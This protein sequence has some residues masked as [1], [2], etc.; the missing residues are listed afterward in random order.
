[1]NEQNVVTEGRR[2]LKRRNAQE[3]EQ[4]IAEYNAGGKSRKEFCEEHGIELS[5]FGGWIK[6]KDAT[7]HAG[8]AEV[9]VPMSEAAPI[10]ITYPAGVRV[11]IRSAGSR[12]DL[13]GL[14]RGL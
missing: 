6:K 11:S 13:V 4:L 14:V 9:M 12:E 8:F 7:A 5:T 2:V 10:E 1:M 3:R